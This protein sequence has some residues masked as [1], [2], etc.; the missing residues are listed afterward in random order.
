LVIRSFFCGNGRS[1]T[2][3]DEADKR[4]IAKFLATLT[5]IF[6]GLKGSKMRDLLCFTSRL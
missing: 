4:Q 3:Q 5:A 1:V 2:P 6:R